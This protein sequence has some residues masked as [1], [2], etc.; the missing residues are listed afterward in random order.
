MAIDHGTAHRQGY[1]TTAKD[2]AKLEGDLQRQRARVAAELALLVVDVRAGRRQM[3]N[4]TLEAVRN[5]AGRL[6]DLDE[7]LRGS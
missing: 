7:A 6:A 5:A 1:R 3:N 4:A 2:A